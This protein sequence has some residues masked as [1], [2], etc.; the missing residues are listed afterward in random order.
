M[1]AD[2]KAYLATL[3]PDVAR[4]L[5]TTAAAFVRDPTVRVSPRLWVDIAA[6]RPLAFE[7]GSSYSYSNTNYVLLGM[8]VERATG[9]AFG[10]VLWSY[11]LEPLR[12]DDTSYVPGPALPRPFARARLTA[13]DPDG[14]LFPGRSDT[15]EVTF[16][17][18]A[19]SAVVATAQDVVRFYRGLLGGDLLLPESLELMKQ[20]SFGLGIYMT[21]CGPAYGHDGGLYGYAAFARVSADGEKAAVLLDNGFQGQ[22]VADDLFCV[23]P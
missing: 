6:A 14:E 7:P 18:A 21:P 13:H 5:E 19:A 11:V 1:M 20:K 3:P 17:I 22:G 23:R 12:L 10:D 15:T 2:P 4:R 16:G 9:E 8:I